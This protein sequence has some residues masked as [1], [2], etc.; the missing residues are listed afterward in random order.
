MI[1]KDIESSKNIVLEKL[2]QLK[3]NGDVFYRTSVEELEKLYELK[4]N[5]RNLRGNKKKKKQ[6]EIA[7][8]EQE[9]KFIVKEYNIFVQNMVREETITQLGDEVSNIDSFIDKEIDVQL[10]MLIENGFIL[11][12]N[13]LLLTEKGNLAI[14]IQELSSLGIAEILKERVFDNLNAIEIASIISC[15]TNLHLS[16]EQ[17]VLVISSIRAPDKVKDV[18]GQIK[19]AYNKYFDILTK[20]KLDIVENYQMHFNMVEL[21]IKWCNALDNESCM[22][23]IQEAKSFDISLGD[24][25]KAIL[26]IN[27][28]SHSSN[29]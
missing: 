25:V 4:M 19:A 8:L 22:K 21:T 15:F 18:I 3:Q 16:D 2:E 17:S 13:E 29:E 1:T 27:N 9:N 10:N 11:K 24:F 7:N 12:E 28:I 6:R 14:N 23:I 26:K 20:L 5:V